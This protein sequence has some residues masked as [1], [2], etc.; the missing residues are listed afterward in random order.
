VIGTVADMLMRQRARNESAR[1]DRAARALV[2][3]GYFPQLT[4][5]GRW[6]TCQKI[7]RIVLQ[8]LS[9]TEEEVK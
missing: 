7:A 8:S 2:K 3:A 9:S 6:V 1:I 4:E 5:V